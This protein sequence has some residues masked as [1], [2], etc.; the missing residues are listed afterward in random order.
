MDVAQ[1]EPAR[2]KTVARREELKTALVLA[3]ERAIAT[4]GLAGLR[5]RDLAAEVGCATGAIYNVFPD[6]DSLILT[7]NARTLAEIGE[8]L[9]ADPLAAK[10]PSRRDAAERLVGL[11]LR[12]LDFAT[13]NLFRWRALFE[14]RMAAGHPVPEWYVGLQAPL[15]GLVEESVRALRPSLGEAEGML[16]ARSM[17]SAVHGVVSLGLEERLIAMPLPQLRNQVA[18]IIR[19]LAAGL[20][21]KASI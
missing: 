16:L 14:H 15:F 18:T 20:A 13:A 12:Y 7:V 5:A 11:G 21:G 6:L 17:F 19:A 8:R 2:G 1:K 3:A 9:G 10:K 4:Q